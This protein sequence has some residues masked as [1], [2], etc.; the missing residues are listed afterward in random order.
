MSNFDKSTLNITKVR[1]IRNRE[2]KTP[3]PEPQV[4]RGYDGHQHEGFAEPSDQ[5][6][7]RATVPPRQPPVAMPHQTYV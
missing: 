1:N 7:A 2:A 5:F 6:V 3:L 4:F